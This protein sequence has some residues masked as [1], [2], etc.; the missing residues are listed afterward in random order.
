MKGF[1]PAFVVDNNDPDKKGRI[2]IRIPH[3]HTDISDDK[4]PYAYPSNI[5]YGNTKEFGGCIIPEKNTWVWVWYEDSDYLFQQPYYLTSITF[6]EIAP[7]QL[8][9]K[10]VKSNVQSQ[11]QYPDTKYI[12]F[13]NG[14]CL[15]IDSSTNNPEITIYH[16]KKTYIFINKDGEIEIKAGDNPTEKTVL[17]ETLKQWLSTHTHMTGVGQSSSPM[18]VS[19]LETILSEK[20][21]HN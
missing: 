18:E 5:V 8:F 14:I 15:A 13:K 20:I 6:S 21:K 16:P 3:F 10:N 2:K 17:G 19:Q 4:L 1:Y 11:S 7:T 12:Y 9:E